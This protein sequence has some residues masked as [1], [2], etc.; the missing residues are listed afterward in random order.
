MVLAPV[1]DGPLEAGDDV[2]DV[3]LPVV[4][5]HLDIDHA[6][7]PGD[8][9]E[10]GEALAAARGRAVSGDDA[11]DMGA[12]A[13]EIVRVCGAVDPVGG[14]P[15]RPALRGLGEVVVEVDTGVEHG[16]ADP[17]AAEAVLL[18]GDACSA[19]DVG[20]RVALGDGAVTGHVRDKREGRQLAQVARRQAQGE[21]PDDGQRTH[22]ARPEGGELR[23]LGSRERAGELDDDRGGPGGA[24]CGDRPARRE[25]RLR[26]GGRGLGGSGSRKGGGSENAGGQPAWVAECV[27]KDVQSFLLPRNR[28]VGSPAAIT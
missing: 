20:E 16:D 6:G 15:G 17:G 4:A 13:A 5:Q 21:R 1:G 22:I 8:A 18:I 25:V 7:L 2:A 9:V 10:V 26:S 3:A 14:D 19:A 24:V 11:G 23:L 27:V 28:A 12:M